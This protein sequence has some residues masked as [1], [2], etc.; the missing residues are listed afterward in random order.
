MNRSAC[1]AWGTRVDQ[2]WIGRS[3]DYDLVRKTLS[4]VGEQYQN[5]HTEPKRESAVQLDSLPIDDFC[6]NASL[7][8]QADSVKWHTKSYSDILQGDSS[9]MLHVVCQVITL[10]TSDI[11]M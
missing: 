3:G 4:C 5:A 11:R 2:A 6:E 8:C 10:M 1:R 7:V 9:V